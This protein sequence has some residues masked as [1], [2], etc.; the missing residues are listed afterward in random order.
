MRRARSDEQ[1]AERRQAVLDAA[2]RLLESERYDAVTMARIGA[3]AGVAKG[4]LYLYFATKEAVF[5]GLVGGMVD[6]WLAALAERLDV[7]AAAEDAPASVRVADAIADT[8]LARPLLVRLLAMLHATL[9]RNV[10]VESIVTWKRGLVQ[11]GLPVAARIEAMLPTLAPGEGLRVLLWVH[12]TLIGMEQA[13]V[14]CPNAALAL[15][16]PDLAPFALN[17]EQEFR[18]GLRA[19]LLGYGR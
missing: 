5:L 10:A 16:E 1:K 4:T 14:P 11:A 6:D 7:V 12:A 17:F 8:L 9:E 3:E 2:A 18:I 15:R 19:L 13:F